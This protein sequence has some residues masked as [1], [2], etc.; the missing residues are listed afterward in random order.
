MRSP[1]GLQMRPSI[2]MPCRALPMFLY[3]WET[4]RFLSPLSGLVFGA[5][6]S[7]SSAIALH[8]IPTLQAAPFGNRTCCHAMHSVCSGQRRVR[9]DHACVYSSQGASGW[10]GRDCMQVQKLQCFAESLLAR[11]H[12]PYTNS[13]CSML[14]SRGSTVAHL[15]SRCWPFSLS[16]EES[17]ALFS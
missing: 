1:N 2:V 11:P 9:L 7:D 17:E 14:R 3:C 13:T 10:S 12:D 8:A 16:V 4:V 5:S 6:K 15:E